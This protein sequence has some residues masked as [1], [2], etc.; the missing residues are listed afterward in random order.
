GTFLHN[1]KMTPLAGIP[2][3]HAEGVGSIHVWMLFDC[4]NRD[5][6]D[7]DIWLIL[8]IVSFFAGYGYIVSFI[9]YFAVKNAN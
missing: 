4:Y 9:Y 5:F 7:R 1:P 3:I 6:K 8:L 2:G